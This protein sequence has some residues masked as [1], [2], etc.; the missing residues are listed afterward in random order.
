MAYVVAQEHRH[1][2]LAERLSKLLTQ[3]LPAYMLPANIVLLTALPLTANGKL[4]TEALPDDADRHAGPDDVVAPRTPVEAAVAR[5]WSELLE[6]DP[7]GV[8]DNFFEIGGHSLVA[9]LMLR[10]VSDEFGVSLP[11]RTIFTAAT[12]ADLAAKVSQEL[13]AR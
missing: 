12:V 1:Q 9:P 2:G 8:T 4:D 10:R 6:R 7:I 13:S 3:Q 5:I 11:L